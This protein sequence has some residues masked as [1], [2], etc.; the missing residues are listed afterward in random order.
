MEN[1][2]V[3]PNYEDIENL[4]LMCLI[5]ES[6]LCIQKAESLNDYLHRVISTALRLKKCI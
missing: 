1:F 6:T 3:F 4:A 2:L 5:L